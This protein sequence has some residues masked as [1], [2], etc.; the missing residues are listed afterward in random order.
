MSKLLLLSGEL[1]EV[2]NLI[3]KD[4]KKPEEVYAEWGL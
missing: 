4:N 3:S 1:N 2:S